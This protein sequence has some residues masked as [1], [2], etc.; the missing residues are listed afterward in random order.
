M[1]H[2]TG[3]PSIKIK[4]KPIAVGSLKGHVLFSTYKYANAHGS[5]SYDERDPHDTSNKGAVF[6]FTQ[7]TYTRVQMMHILT[8][9]LI[10]MLM[11]WYSLTIGVLR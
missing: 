3:D 4:L 8:F 11:L 7:M 5:T 9:I 1:L 2:A 6:D 10:V